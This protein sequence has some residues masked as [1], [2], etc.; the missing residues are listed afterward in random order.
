MPDGIALTAG[1]QVNPRLR[2]VV[3][4]VFEFPCTKP[5][6]FQV[7]GVEDGICMYPIDE[8]RPAPS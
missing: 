2:P 8:Y 4:L 6:P 1:E 5:Y 3:L 7:P